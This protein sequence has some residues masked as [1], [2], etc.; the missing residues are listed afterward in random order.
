MVSPTLAPPGRKCPVCQAVANPEDVTLRIFAAD[1]N[2]IKGGI[3]ASREYLRGMGTT[4]SDRTIDNRVI[5]HRDHIEKFMRAPHPVAPMSRPEGVSRIDHREDVRF[6]TYEQKALN[7]G[8]Q[9][10]EE[11]SRMLDT[12]GWGDEA[13]VVAA[14]KIGQAV[15]AKKGDRAARGIDDKLDQL[16]RLAAGMPDPA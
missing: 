14:A 1:G 8:A 13:T 12:G 5:T 7:V 2:R 6:P 10:L 3:A 9:A 11:L 15:A 4:G 16:A